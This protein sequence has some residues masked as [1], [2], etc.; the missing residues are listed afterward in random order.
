MKR[1]RVCEACVK[2]LCVCAVCVCACMRTSESKRVVI[3]PARHRRLIVCPLKLTAP[4]STLH[5]YIIVGRAA[6]AGHMETFAQYRLIVIVTLL[7]TVDCYIPL[8]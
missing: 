3:C 2:H 7:L 6:S 1:V 8:L 4:S 5:K